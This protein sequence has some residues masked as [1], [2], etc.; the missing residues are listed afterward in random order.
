MDEVV[1]QVIHQWGGVMGWVRGVSQVFVSQV[2]LSE[3]S[4]SQV[5][6]LLERLHAAGTGE[7][8][9]YTCL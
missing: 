4:W 3:L 2:S 1:Q 6:S 7:S 9:Y 5:E 8:S